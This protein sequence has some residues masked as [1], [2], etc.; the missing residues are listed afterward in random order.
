[1]ECNITNNL[2]S[3]MGTQTRTRIFLL[4]S[5]LFLSPCIAMGQTAEQQDAIELLKTTARSLK[6]EPDK[7]AAGRLQARIAATLWKFDEPFARET[8]RSAFE[9][10]AQSVA[11]D[12]P[13]EKQASFLRRQAIAVRDVLRSFG[14]HDSKQAAEWLKAFENDR[15]G[16]SS[17]KANSLRPELLMQIAGQIALSDPEQATRLGL[18]A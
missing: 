14:V 6:S 5:V 2:F 3:A 13:K 1:M 11:D 18:V 15:A 7:I 17:E 10:I 4:L 16:K 8:F 12:L 9:G